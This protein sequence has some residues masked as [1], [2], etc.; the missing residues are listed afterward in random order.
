[1]GRLG[2][3]SAVKRGP[4][5]AVARVRDAERTLRGKQPKHTALAKQ[6]HAELQAART[7]WAYRPPGFSTAADA[8]IGVLNGDDER[9]FQGLVQEASLRSG[10]LVQFGTLLG[11]TA[12]QMCLLKAADQQVVTV[13]A[14]D[15]NPWQLAPDVY[16]ALAR[17][18][19]RYLIDA[20]HVTRTTLSVGEFG[21][22][23]RG[24][25][26]ALVFINYVRSY[27]EL[28]LIIRWARSVGA[29][30]IAG[31]NYDC[32]HPDVL[33]AVDEIGGPAAVEGNLWRLDAPPAAQGAADGMSPELAAPSSVG[34]P[35]TSIIIPAYNARNFIQAALDD[36]GRQ[37]YR[38]WEL[39]VVE[40][41]SVEDV[42]SLVV[43]FASHHPGRRVV[44]RR[45]PQ[46]A[47]VSSARNDAMA[48]CQG[49]Y[50]AFL[51]ADDRWL[52]DHLQRKVRLLE[53]SG[54]DLAYS[55]VEMFDSD[56]GRAMCIWGPTDD[57]IQRFP[58]SMFARPYLQPSGV[59]ARRSLLT[60]L[61]PFDVTL[62]Y[63]E[64]YDYWFRAVA[65]GKRF[66]FDGKVTS[67]YRKN[68]ASA[69]TTDRLVLCF[70]GVAKVACRYL[71]LLGVDDVQRRRI[72]ARNFLIAGAG[73]MAFEPTPRNGCRPD[74]AMG[75][76]RQ[77]WELH[78][79][80]TKYLRYYVLA[81][82]A[83]ATRAVRFVRGVFRRKFYRCMP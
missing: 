51:D 35:L 6:I 40:D 50:V 44:Y 83:T 46:N 12:A 61:G 60:E 37:T 69:A 7:V 24:A 8:E 70:E 14:D 32:S 29:G 71:G 79:S 19:L 78:G 34:Q 82:M 20:G 2:I 25:P 27:D 1:M 68:H 21:S 15:A 33:R 38:N 75:L 17:S 65:A 39:I 23:Y 73:H 47:G 77:A 36:V 63:A 62:A 55:R 67:R 66:A 58:E 4:K 31:R 56:T 53:S 74:A 5:A 80:R 10:P 49:D 28:R 9:L 45:K 18:A 22:T 13:D 11:E 26:P 16:R 81:R 30:A 57:E 3:L 43:E 42:E 52:A 41:G 48:L 64:D 54:A 72:V 59:V 76:L